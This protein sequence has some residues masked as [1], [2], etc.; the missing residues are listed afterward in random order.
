MPPAE[1]SLESPA[2]FAGVALQAVAERAGFGVWGLDSDGQV[3]YRNAVAARLIGAGRHIHPDDRAS[4]DAARHGLQAPGDHYHLIYRMRDAQGQVFWL[5]ETAVETQPSADGLVVVGSVVDITAQLTTE[6]RLSDALQRT[7]GILRTATDAIVTVD[8]RR[9][10]VSFNHAAERLFGIA[11]A[12]VLGRPLACWLRPPAGA[13]PAPDLWSPQTGT[14]EMRVAHQGGSMIPVAVSVSSLTLRG[15]VLHT[16]ILRDIRDSLRAQQRLEAAEARQRL[17]LQAA[18]MGV[19][20]LDPDSGRLRVSDE[21]C[22]VFGDPAPQTLE[23][24]D[25]LLRV[26][27]P[28]D[29]EAVKAVWHAAV[30]VGLPFE[31]A[32][33]IVD[34]G[35][36]TRWIGER[37]RRVDAPHQPRVLAV[38]MDI[39][40]RK[41]FETDAQ[42]YAQILEE[43]RNEIYL[44]AP[45]TLQFVMVN[46]P[47]RSNLGYGIEE[48]RTLT[49]LTLKPEYTEAVFRQMIAPL[50]QGRVSELRFETVHRRKDGSHYPVEVVLRYSAYDLSSVFVAT[51]L[52]T[53]ERRDR[54]HRLETLAERLRVLSEQLV[55]VQEHERRHLARELHDEIGQQLTAGLMRVRDP[56]VRLSAALRRD[57]GERF[58][59][60]IEQVRNLS[61]DLRPAVL[62]DLGLAPALRWYAE[63][64]AA[65]GRL[66]LEMQLSPPADRPS[67]EVETALFRIAQEAMTNVLR[68][69]GAERLRL[70]LTLE[71][72][73]LQL[74][75]EDDGRGFDPAKLPP[76][77]ERH[78]GLLGMHERAR[79]LGGDVQV[80]SLAG[81]GTRVAAWV[82]LNP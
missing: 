65:L 57:L 62:D 6:Q 21:A 12:E 54:E 63:R 16:L 23:T 61:L 33:R 53:S 42:R 45:D 64:Q 26:V 81:E 41:R 77:T 1:S 36:G 19:W 43:S 68:H 32:Y 35:G 80:T 48:L 47:A 55:Q 8:E 56:T 2:L 22:A 29:R 11:A 10:L 30:E 69:A 72:Q 25:Q 5:E 39:T 4:V 46:K 44:F 9:H 15:G 31:H 79:L 71:G 75:I 82:P 78:F 51:I 3:V 14:T 7:E 76:V 40:Q 49:P 74:V 73:R 38:V 24:V 59:A 60:L 20:Q 18:G 70:S 58:N 28:A 34:A 66:Q 13:E 27:H 50:Q 37:G 67:P 52:D 17:A